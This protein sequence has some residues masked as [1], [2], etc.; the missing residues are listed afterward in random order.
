MDKRM[1]QMPDDIDILLGQR[2]FDKKTDD[3]E[4]DYYFDDEPLDRILYGKDLSG[5]SP[6]NLY[7]SA[8]RSVEK[9]ISS[10]REGK[11]IDA[12]SAAFELGSS[13]TP[14]SIEMCRVIANVMSEVFPYYPNPVIKYDLSGLRPLFEKIW[15]IASEKSAIGLQGKAGLLLFRWYEHHGKYEEARHILTRLIELY[16]KECD[17][18]EEAIMLNNLG[19]E[20]LLEKRWHE[21]ILNFEKATE[22]FKEERITFQYANARANYWTCRFALND[23]GDIT[24]TETE[25]K[26]IYQ[27]LGGA[28]QWYGRKPFILQAKLEER[29]GNIDKAINLVEQ[30][31]DSAKDSN[32]RYPETDREYLEFLQDALR[33]NG[34]DRLDA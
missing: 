9:I 3:K 11:M 20:Y 2:P 26:E 4:A 15:R 30:A 18:Q 6:A 10:C 31:I 13:E 27:V 25:L 8:R 29:R 28:R 23:F 24:D 1:R 32:T 17:R 33:E 19:F 5:P 21:A 7:L 16:R 34:E 12:I 22:I 14:L